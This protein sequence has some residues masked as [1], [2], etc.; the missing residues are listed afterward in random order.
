MMKQDIATKL[1][2]LLD[3]R[4]HMVLTEKD[5]ELITRHKDAYVIISMNPVSSEFAG[6]KPLNAA[7]RRRMTVWLNFDYMSIGEHIDEK[8]IDMI[9]ERSSVD[10]DTAKK[11]I[12]VGA[13]QRVMYKTGD[14]P[15]APSIGDL[16]N[17]AKIISDGISPQVAA[18]E[19]LVTMTSDDAEVQ[20]MVRKLINKIFT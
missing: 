7:F 14:L 20:D 1:N 4:G 16:V 6:T 19:T 11:I 15:Y 17:W 18:D 5:N 10:R 3:T 2:P 13:E 9:E 12:L 8:E